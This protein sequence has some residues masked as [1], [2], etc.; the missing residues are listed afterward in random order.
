MTRILTHLRGTPNQSHL[1]LRVTE[2]YGRARS[3][4]RP[5]VETGTRQVGT[6]AKKQWK[7]HRARL[8]DGGDLSSS[9][10]AVG[11]RSRAL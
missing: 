3:C 10:A 1:N 4:L 8:P 7:V 9:P 11:V 2:S 6:A 5:L